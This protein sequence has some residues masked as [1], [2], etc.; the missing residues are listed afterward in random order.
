MMKRK[1]RYE[2]VSDLKKINHLRSL[3]DLVLNFSRYHI[4]DIQTPTA[5]GL[6]DSGYKALVCN[7]IDATDETW[8]IAFMFRIGREKKAIWHT[9]VSVDYILIDP[10]SRITFTKISNCV[11]L[12]SQFALKH[13]RA[14]CVDLL[15][16]LD[17]QLNPVVKQHIVEALVNE[18]MTRSADGKSCAKRLRSID[19]S[20]GRDTVSLPLPR[21]SRSQVKGMRPKVQ[22][23]IRAQKTKI[24]ETIRFVGRIQ[25]GSQQHKAILALCAKHPNW[26]EPPM[27]AR[28]SYMQT[29]FTNEPGDV[30]KWVAS[31]VED[32][33][34]IVSVDDAGRV[35]SFMAFIVGYSTPALMTGE[36]SWSAPGDYTDPERTLFV[37][38]VV[39]KA[40]GHGVWSKDGFQ[41]AMA[42][43]RMLFTVLAE[44][45]NSGLF[46][47]VAAQVDDGGLHS[48]LLDAL[49]FAKKASYS[50]LPYSPKATDLYAR[51]TR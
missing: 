12:I 36:G 42:L 10:S 43:W 11:R 34:F 5:F 25:P 41:Q 31:L 49:G 50:N 2:L 19:A 20:T 13:L 8:K 4:V 29:L 28:V 23:T 32:A 17:S 35:S 51:S 40:R 47:V 39:C 33:H 44:P 18:G 7:E 45:G 9:V 30:R 27:D 37:P 26:L 1:I 16:N 6:A 15:V 3:R 48:F 46:D 22:S 14:S 38:A 21:V 24:G